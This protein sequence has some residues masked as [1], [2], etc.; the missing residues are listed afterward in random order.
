MAPIGSKRSPGRRRWWWSDLGRRVVPALY[1]NGAGVAPISWAGAPVMRQLSGGGPRVS[2]LAGNNREC[3]GRRPA[4]IPLLVADN[5]GILC[6]GVTQNDTFG[7]ITGHLGGIRRCIHVR[8]GG[9]ECLYERRR[10]VGSPGSAC[11]QARGGGRR[12]SYAA[13]AAASGS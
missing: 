1:N 9:Y 8:P 4:V 10:R 2:L 11:F 13:A 12:H 6:P 3:P 7:H 5:C